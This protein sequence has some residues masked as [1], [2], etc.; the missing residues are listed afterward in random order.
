MWDS[1]RD[2]NKI[3]GSFRSRKMGFFEHIRGKKWKNVKN[4]CP[5]IN[6]PEFISNHAIVH[7]NNINNW[8]EM[9]H[10]FLIR[11]VEKLPQKTCAFCS[12][13]FTKKKDVALLPCLDIVH[14]KC[15]KS[16]FRG[17]IFLYQKNQNCI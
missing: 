10:K 2:S 6:Y 8:K 16:K 13:E 12:K 11:E 17:F 14:Y 1:W 3:Q 9:N 5:P 4:L 7:T 15:L